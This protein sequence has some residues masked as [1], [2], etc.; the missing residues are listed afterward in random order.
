[1][2]ACRREEG[3][4]ARELRGH[5]ADAARAP[6]KVGILGAGAIGSV[7]A[8][9]LDRGRAAAE[10]IA[11]ADQDRDKAEAL[12]ARLASCPPVVGLDELI[13][14]TELVV[15]AASQAAVAELI[16]K[17]L[18]RRRD[19]LVLSVGGLLGHDDWFREA[20][21]RGCRIYVPSGAIGGL[22]AAR[23]AAAGRIDAALLTSRKPIAALKG[24]LYVRER[25][26]DLDRLTQETVIFEGDA[27]QAAR[28]FPATSNVAASVRLALGPQA[29]LRVRVAAVPGGRE[30]VHELKLAGEFG[31]LTM[32][33]ENVPSK[34]NPRTSQLAAF[35]A[36]AALESLTRS[37]RVGL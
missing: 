32:I 19:A 21:A 22:D 33:V 34:S 3:A 20:H 18:Q 25:G 7:L 4:P 14:R 5:L 37:L 13:E 36:V 35:S 27:E 23:A 17:A 9:A 15:E 10:L 2:K 16:P 24:A 28:A 11:L 12:A 8:D 1:M 6:L 26:I 30:N 29:P 31:R